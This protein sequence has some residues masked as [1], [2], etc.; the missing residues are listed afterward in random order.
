MAYLSV[1][2]PA[3]NS[4]A[5]IES[6]LQAIRESNYPNYELIVI[7]DGSRDKTCSIVERYADKV[8]RLKENYGR[9]YARKVGIEAS[10][11]EIV[12]NI[13]SDVVIKQ[14]TIIRIVNYF[15]KHQNIDAITGILSKDCPHLNFF[16]QYKNLYMHYMFKRLPEKITYLLG[17]IYALRRTVIAM[18]NYDVRYADDTALGQQIFLSGKQI[19]LLKD[20]EVAH[21]KKYDLFSFVKND[22]LIPFDWAKIFLRYKGWRQ[23]GRNKTGFAHV[24]IRQLMGVALAP[25]I[26]LMLIAEIFNASFLPGL[27]FLISAWFMFSSHFIVSLAKE[28]GVLFG[29][30]ASFA[31][32]FDNIIMFLGILCGFVSYIFKA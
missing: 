26:I 12:I 1:I 7:D 8:V 22:F 6:C 5:T 20:L 31:T 29:L 21:L 9:N 15:K 28:K 17:S 3:Y 27:L 2:V 11:G 23:L 18:R 32:F 16:S 14:D 4:E 10:E 19:V 25:M 24:S 30:L 13:D